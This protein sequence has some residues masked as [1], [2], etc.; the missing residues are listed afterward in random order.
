MEVKY[1]EITV[2]LSG[3][4]GNAMCIIAKV[5]KALKRGDVSK[6]EVDKFCEEATSGNYDNVLV[7]AMKWINVE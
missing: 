2:Q 4:D 3:E 7:T 6:E 5:R 1:P